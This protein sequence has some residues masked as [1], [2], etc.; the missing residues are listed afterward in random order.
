AFA[1]AI[2]RVANGGT[3]APVVPGAGPKTTPTQIVGGG[4]ATAALAGGAVAGAALADSRTQVIP[5][6]GPGALAA[7]GGPVT[8]PAGPMP[9]LQTPP[10]DDWDAVDD[11]GPRGGRGKWA[12]LS[13]ALVLLLLLVGGTWFLLHDGN[14]GTGGATAGTTTAQTSASPTGILLDPAAFVGR[15]ADQVQTELKAARLT[16]TQ[17]DADDEELANAGVA[18]DAGDVAGLR[19]SGVL[20]APGTPVVLYV[21][22]KAY[23]PADRGGKPTATTRATTTPPPTTT[24]P[25]TTTP[26]PTTTSPATT[27]SLAPGTSETPPSDPTVSPSAEAPA[28]QGAE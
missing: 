24:A 26:P 6:T 22:Q 3:L 7:A 27:T 18:L 19:P 17:R 2:R 8:G 5:A 25:P 1:E 13:A 4:A 16:V 28:A 10:G 11:D 9:P 23:D 21:A 15:P 12:W 20:A 14:R